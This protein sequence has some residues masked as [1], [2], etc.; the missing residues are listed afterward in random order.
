MET[1]AGSKKLESAA[2]EEAYK[3]WLAV[4]IAIVAL[5]VSITTYLHTDVSN[6]GAALSRLDQQDAIL[7]TGVRTRGQLDTVFAGEIV[8]EYDEL[9]DQANSLLYNDRSIEASAFISAANQVAQ[10]S[11]LLSPTYTTL[12][13]TGWRKSTRYASYEADTWVVTST[14]LAERREAAAKEGDALG[15]KGATLIAAIAVFAVSLFLFA[16]SST[17]TGWVRLLFLSVGLALTSVTFLGV[18][19]TSLWPVPHIPDEAL[20]EFAQG[21]GYHWQGRY[22]EAEDAYSR[23]LAIYSGYAN[24]LSER[25]LAW[26]HVQPPQVDR[27]VQDLALASRVAQDNYHVFWNLGWAFYRAGD[28]AKSIEASET[29]LRLNPKMCGPAFN[30]ALARL[31]M[32]Q[33]KQAE[34]DYEAAIARCENILLDSFAA[35]SAA[36]YS[37]W[38]EISA[39]AQDIE[40]LLCQTHRK[41]CYPNREQIDIRRVGNRDAVRDIGDKYLK[42]IS[43]AL[44]ALEYLHTATVKPSGAKFQP[45]AFG[46]EFTND[47]GDFQ[48]YVVRDRFPYR[49]TSIY[50][51]WDYADV[52][53][54]TE[55]VWKIY[56]DGDEQ[57]E[58]RYEGKW[59]LETTGSATKE[60]NSWFVMAPGLYDVQVYGDG[61][62]LASGSFQIDEKE[63]LNVPTNA[64]VPPSVAVPVGQ[65]LLYDDFAD[66][67]HGW[68]S[69]SGS[70]A[71]GTL[72]NATIQA[73]EYRMVSHRQDNKW[74]V[75]CE[76]CGPFADVYYEATARLVKGP[77]DYGYGLALRGDRGMDEMYLFLVSEAGAF[78]IARVVDGEYSSLTDWKTSALIRPGSTNRL[79]VLARG[80][81]LEFFINGQSAV[82][83]TNDA[84][85]NGYVG[86]TVETSEM[87]IAFSQVRVWQAR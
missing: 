9:L 44:V 46:N 80:N 3:R 49:S 70:A 4:L 13:E 7:S 23:A 74:R 37:L 5:L 72:K 11:P 15:G 40:N 16:L 14:F 45:L 59:G 43:E 27:A 82:Q 52:K 42:R 26:L 28:Y 85:S 19:V 73:G 58:L 31:A 29:A 17:I 34:I 69:T 2:R 12:D 21:R 87:E 41:H 50:A 86:F 47:A 62:M 24:A 38:S 6:R 57:T 81:S 68:W 39:S 18:V 61:E 33:P 25:G 54:E 63:T 67:H 10:Q 84:L 71:K 1:S 79:G 78:K 53:P 48:A 65:L 76:D 30:V 20:K 8:R 83:T 66:N 35:G 36:P 75:T 55:M 22:D 32:G 51:I 56:L 60:I 64:T 77:K